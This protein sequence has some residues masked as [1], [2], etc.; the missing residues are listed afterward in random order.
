MNST[1]IEL[2]QNAFRRA[3]QTTIGLIALSMVLLSIQSV[4]QWN[5]LPI[6]NASVWWLISALNL[7]LFVFARRY[8]ELKPDQKNFLYIKLFL[9]WTTICIIRGA[10]VAEF[11]WDWKNLTFVAFVLLQP[12]VVFIATNPELVQKFFSTWI[13][14]AFPVFFLL[15]PFLE[16]EAYGKFLIPISILL[17]FFPIL[18]KKWKVICLLMTIS[19][20][21][22]YTEARSNILKFI[23]PFAMSFIY[24]IRGIGLTK[25]IKSANAFFYILP[26]ILLILA[27]T[28]TFNVFNMESYMGRIQSNQVNSV[29]EQGADLTGDTRTLIYEEMIISAFQNDYVLFGRTPARGYDSTLF[30]EEAYYNLHMKRMERYSSE[31][32]ILNIFTWLGTVGVI[33]YLLSFFRASYLAIYR[34]NNTFIKIVGL[35]VA[36]RWVFAWI[37]D[38]SRFDLSNL[39][40]WVLISMCLSKTFRNMTDRE[41][42]IWFLGIFERKYEKLSRYLNLQRRLSSFGLLE[43]PKPVGELN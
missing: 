29:G 16:G 37:E 3:K 7:G 38:F 39:F 15:F 26:V 4:N 32:S 8:F 22:L 1:R 13:K 35:Y 34:S 30:G 17:L 33:L 43:P 31:V 36:F 27:V 14:Y 11:Y 12:L 41:F 19:T 25:L 2:S 18:P 21:V 28:G 9:L 24:Y 23:I 20:A 5:T 40:L 6:D 10:F 42:R